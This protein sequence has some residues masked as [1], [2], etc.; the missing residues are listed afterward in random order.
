MQTSRYILHPD[1]CGFFFCRSEPEFAYCPSYLRIVNLTDGA[2]IANITGSC[3]HTFGSAM[4]VS[5]SGST[6]ETLYVFSSRWARFQAPHPWCPSPKGGAAAWGGECERAGTCVID[7][8]SSADPALQTWHSQATLK[9]SFKAYNTDV[10]VVPQSRQLMLPTV[11]RVS[12]VMAVEQPGGAA[13]WQSTIFVT[14]ASTPMSGWVGLAA[15]FPTPGAVRNAP[16]ACPCIRYVAEDGMFYVFGAGSFAGGHQSVVLVRSPDLRTWEPALRPLLSPNMSAGDAR[17]MDGADFNLMSFD[18]NQKYPAS[19]P[20]ASVSGT[21]AK[22]GWDK[23]AADM[24]AVEV[25][26]GGYFGDDTIVLAYWGASDQA[27]WGFG[28]LAIFNGSMAD[29]L[30]APFQK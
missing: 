30:L 26:G 28:Q 10:V 16:V 13:G 20:F 17:P 6:P 24:D 19:G 25:P 18:P 12:Y 21:F 14:N 1:F 22:G 23:S 2:V 5:K 15:L 3:N 27:R 11:G 8:F 4:V 29:Y 7:S 9:P